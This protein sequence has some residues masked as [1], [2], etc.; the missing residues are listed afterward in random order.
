MDEFDYDPGEALFGDEFLTPVY[1]GKEVLVRYLYD[2]R[3]H[4]DFASDTYGQVHGDGFS[5]AF[6]I[7]ANGFVVAWLGDLRQLP[8][9]EQ[10]HWRGEN[11]P[12][13]HNPRSEFF[14]A[15]IGAQFTPP[16]AALRCLNAV[17]EMNA[18]FHEKYGVHLYHER[19]LESRLDDARRYRRLVMGHKDDFKR[20]I[21]ELN[22]IIN[23]SVD[24]SVVRQFVHTRGLTVA[25]GARGNKL[26]QAVYTGVLGD[27]ENLIAPF[28]YLYDL[29]LWADH[30]VP[31]ERRNEIVTALG[32]PD[33]EDYE[34]IMDALLTRMG[35][36]AR[37]LTVKIKAA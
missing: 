6:G 26:L 28:F 30:S 4:C 21:S 31:D 11:R 8:Q 3:F 22:E 1:F 10:L 35:D 16:P 27:T 15:Q 32:V 29:R 2:P 25:D 19:P 37:A 20:F 23:E 33:P 17:A 14:D 24:H 12:S 36:A 18:A 5:M 7:N 34:R 13:D 9:K